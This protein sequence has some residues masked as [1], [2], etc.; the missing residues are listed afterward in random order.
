MQCAN[1][2]NGLCGLIKCGIHLG[3]L[4]GVGQKRMGEG[5][6]ALEHDA[7]VG[8]SPGK[9]VQCFSENKGLFLHGLFCALI[10]MYRGNFN[11]Q[12]RTQA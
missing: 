9:L 8:Y 6:V 4:G 5:G 12:R 2:T 11:Q 7:G 10:H 3:V 1:I